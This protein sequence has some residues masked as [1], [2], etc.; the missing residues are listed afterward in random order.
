MAI[1][2]ETATSDEI[3]TWANSQDWTNAESG[4]REQV[5]AIILDR[6]LKET[7][8]S[9][10]SDFE[11]KRD[12]KENDQRAR[13]RWPELKNKES[14]LYKKVQEKLDGNP[15]ALTDPFALLN[16]ANDVGLSLGLLPANM[17]PERGKNE[18]MD[19]IAGGAGSNAQAEDSTDAFLKETEKIGAAF[20]DLINLKDEKVRERIAANAE[21]EADNNG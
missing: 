10:M 17:L 5:D 20:G 21:R 12:G 19:G 15:T 14:E 16:A 1:N 2:F 18:P 3:L 4:V 7:V 8:S 13:D 9:A 6:K 11:R